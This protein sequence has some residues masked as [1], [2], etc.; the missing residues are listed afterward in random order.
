MAKEHETRDNLIIAEIG[1]LRGELVS[2][3]EEINNRMAPIDKLKG[4]WSVVGFILGALGLI[5]A[6]LAGLTYLANFIR[7]HLPH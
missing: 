3:K 6:G 4:F 5:A 2:F 1:K 7:N